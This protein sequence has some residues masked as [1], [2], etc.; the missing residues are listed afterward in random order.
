MGVIGEVQRTYTRDTTQGGFFDMTKYNYD[1]GLHPG[2]R[3]PRLWFARGNEVLFFT[4]STVKG[5]YAISSE[6]YIKNGKWSK[7]EYVLLLGEGVRAIELLSPLHGTWGQD[8]NSWEEVANTLK[9][10]IGNARKIVTDSYPS[11]AKR[12]NELED[13]LK[14]SPMETPTWNILKEKLTFV[15]LTPDEIL[16]VEGET[17]TI[18]PTSGKVAWVASTTGT[19]ISGVLWTG[20]ALGEVVDLP[21]PEVGKIYIVSG[22]VAS[23][24]GSTRDD[25]FSLGTGPKDEPLRDE[26]NQIVGVTRL[27]RSH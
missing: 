11:Q 21:P 6:N 8:L 26:Q 10:S 1:D 22:L 25:V 24:V 16:I 13:F 5:W 18:V 27:I 19:Q 4:G 15:N 12:L 9:V 3:R 20:T 23:R 17:T 2:N 7:T 14:P